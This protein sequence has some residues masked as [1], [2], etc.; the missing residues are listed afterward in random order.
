LIFPIIKQVVETDPILT[1]LSAKAIFKC[2]TLS[3]ANFS[4]QIID[5]NI[6]GIFKTK[7]VENYGSDTFHIDFD[8]HS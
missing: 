1:Q 3:R 8:C 5:L 6:E 2:K 7:Q 4:L